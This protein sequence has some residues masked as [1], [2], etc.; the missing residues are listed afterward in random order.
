MT[1]IVMTFNEYKQTDKQSIYVL[2]RYI[3]EQEQCCLF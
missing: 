3:D 2:Y 1:F